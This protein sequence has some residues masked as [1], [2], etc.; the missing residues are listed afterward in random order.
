MQNRNGDKHQTEMEGE[1]GK[2]LRETGRGGEKERKLIKKR[3]EM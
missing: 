2:S 1:G 3:D